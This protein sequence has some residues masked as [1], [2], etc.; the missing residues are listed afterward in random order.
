MLEELETTYSTAKKGSCCQNDCK[1]DMG[2]RKGYRI[3]KGELLRDEHTILKKKSLKNGLI[4]MCDC[5]IIMNEKK[6]VLVELKCKH[7]KA[8]ET[9]EQLTNAAELALEITEKYG[10]DFEIFFFILV[11]G[12][13]H[14][15]EVK[16]LRR[17]RPRVF[18][19]EYN[20]TIGGD[21]CLLDDL[22]AKHGPGARASKSTR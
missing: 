3:F 12:R 18:E 4:K 20:A 10:S 14:P 2:S 21:R 16:L 13:M 7:A 17:C 22:I 5:I 15:M 11:C 19:K 6:I 8:D 1:L 9:E